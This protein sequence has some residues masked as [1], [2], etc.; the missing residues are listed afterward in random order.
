MAD[1][2]T[3]CGGWGLGG[4]LPGGCRPSLYPASHLATRA[5]T[6]Q[7]A[8]E[9]IQRERGRGLR[10]PLSASQALGRPKRN[11]TDGDS[12]TKAVMIPSTNAYLC[13]DMMGCTN[14]RK[15][16]ALPL[17]G[18]C[19]VGDLNNVTHITVLQESLWGVHE[20]GEQIQEERLPGG[21]E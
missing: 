17:K 18:L 3:P 13:K 4:V 7:E 5:E 9:S 1:Q 15:V 16:W 10:R 21:G 11:T 20:E 2:V 14:L 6:S 12:D 8:M 19:F